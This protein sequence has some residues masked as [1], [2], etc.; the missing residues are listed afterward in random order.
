MDGRDDPVADALWPPHWRRLR[1]PQVPAVHQ[2][3]DAVVLG[4]DRVR[5]GEG[6]H[7]DRVGLDL[8][9]PLLPLVGADGADDAEGALLGQRLGRRPTTPR[10]RPPGSRPPARSPDPS[11]RISRKRRPF[12][13]R[14]LYSH[15][16]TVTVSPT[17]SGRGGDARERLGHVRG[18]G[19]PESY[20]RRGGR[21]MPPSAERWRQPSAGAVRRSGFGAP[22][23][24]RLAAPAESGGGRADGHHGELR[25]RVLSNP[26]P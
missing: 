24:W 15:P 18:V 17:W 2:E 21:G 4:R 7:L 6:Q 12:E 25:R 8:D 10:R 13:P 5:L 19:E 16:L 9:A 22:W 26:E 14:A 20:G 23:L 11:S 1:K 3:L